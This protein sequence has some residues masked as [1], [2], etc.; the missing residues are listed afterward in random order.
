MSTDLPSWVPDW[1]VHTFA[2][3]LASSSKFQQWQ[4]AKA[5]D[6]AITCVEDFILCR[7]QAVDAIECMGDLFFEYVPVSGSMLGHKKSSQGLME[8][9]DAFARR[10]WKLW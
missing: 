1:E 2:T 10:R 5:S 3:P 9:R 4:A 7:G 8:T 6:A